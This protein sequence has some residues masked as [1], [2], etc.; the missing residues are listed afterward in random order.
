[1]KFQNF[2]FGMAYNSVSVAKYFDGDKV[3]IQCQDTYGE[4]IGDCRKFPNIEA[5]EK[6]I[7]YVCGD[8]RD[9]YDVLSDLIR[10][11]DK[12]TVDEYHIDCEG[13]A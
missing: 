4:K 6:F 12:L 10:L 3:I 7:D 11:I 5:Y 2:V 13:W 1:M 8:D 9:P